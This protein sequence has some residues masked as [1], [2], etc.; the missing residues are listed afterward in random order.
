LSLG[1]IDGRLPQHVGVL[2]VDDIEIGRWTQEDLLWHVGEMVA[3]RCCGGKARKTKV[4]HQC[5]WFGTDGRGARAEIR[6][7]GKDLAGEIS[8]GAGSSHALVCVIWLLLQVS[9][10]EL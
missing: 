7:E 2:S 9:G 8:T 6:F 5:R 3:R 10:G 1:A 4:R